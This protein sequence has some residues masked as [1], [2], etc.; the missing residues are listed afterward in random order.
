MQNQAEVKLT[1]DEFSHHDKKDSD[2]DAVIE[3][4][5]KTGCNKAEAARL[6]GID[7]RTIYRK[8][9]RYGIKDDDDSGD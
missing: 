9:E 4:L 7:R 5:K 8:M 2:R 3:A 6:M 1:D